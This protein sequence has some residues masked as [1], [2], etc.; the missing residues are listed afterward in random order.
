MDQNGFWWRLVNLNPAVLRGVVVAVV[1]LLGTV[2]ILVTP[3]LPDELVAAL[4]AVAAVVQALWTR[5]AVTPNARVVVRAP[6]P[7]TEPGVVEAG[8]ATTIAPNLDIL[9]AAGRRVS[10]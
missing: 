2:G 3:A 9:R 10:G 8:E 1:A 7:I 4:A 5:A 6:E